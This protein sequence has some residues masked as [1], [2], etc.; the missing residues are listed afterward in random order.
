MGSIILAGVAF[1]RH[2][3]SL[4]YSTVNEKVTCLAT[5]RCGSQI[6]ILIFKGYGDTQIA[7]VNFSRATKC[8]FGH[9]SVCETTLS[10][11]FRPFGMLN[12][13]C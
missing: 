5:C 10:E 13:C 2:Q 1:G 4:I 8:R 11:Y 7:P 12:L 3:F 9:L 6:P